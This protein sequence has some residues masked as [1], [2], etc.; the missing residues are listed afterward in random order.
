MIQLDVEIKDILLKLLE[1]QTRLD[2]KV[3]G[4]ETQVRKNSIKLETIEK[5]LI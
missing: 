3:S 5:I 4:L 2:G 1:G